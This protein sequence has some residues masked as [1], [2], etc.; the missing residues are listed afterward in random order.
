MHSVAALTS[1]AASLCFPFDA[2]APTCSE[3]FTNRSDLRAL[4][5]DEKGAVPACLHCAEAAGLPDGSR[6]K[7][8]AAAACSVC[9]DLIS[10]VSVPC[11]ACVR[12]LPSAAALRPC[13]TLTTHRACGACLQALP[14]VND[15]CAA[16]ARSGDGAACGRCWATAGAEREVCGECFSDHP[17]VFG[18]DALYGR[19]ERTNGAL[20]LARRFQARV[21]AY[22]AAGIAALLSCAGW[23][24]AARREHFTGTFRELS[25]FTISAVSVVCYL[26]IAAEPIRGWQWPRYLLWFLA[27]PPH[28]VVLSGMGGATFA[29]LVLWLCATA[30]TA[31]VCAAIGSRMPALAGAAFWGLAVLLF[32]PGLWV[33]ASVLWSNTAEEGRSKAYP[34]V[35]SA[36]FVNTALF[37]TL[38]V[39]DCLGWVS[40]GVDV[41]CFVAVDVAT[42]AVFCLVAASCGADSNFK[43]DDGADASPA[44]HLASPRQ[45]REVY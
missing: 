20:Y 24:C 8:A 5:G 36:F 6:P 10:Q 31:V 28:L 23:K 45:L 43:W 38:W 32:L 30:E 14:N 7:A 44:R 25:V 3:C 27:T 16:C 26:A 42:R 11:A 9:R 15:G 13:R 22:V 12:S 1:I 33:L 40:E 29:D 39:L 17:E 19:S 18:A 34:A 21:S 37:P 4:H 2:I 35:A 41:L